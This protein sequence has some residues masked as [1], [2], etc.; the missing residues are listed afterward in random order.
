MAARAY[1]LMPPDNPMDGMS[2]TAFVRRS[3]FMN[4]YASPR[5]NQA[6]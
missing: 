1:G 2:A 5:A 3:V 6:V 4:A